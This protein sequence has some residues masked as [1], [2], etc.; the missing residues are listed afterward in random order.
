MVW[1]KAS[2]KYEMDK[3]KKL[4]HNEPTVVAVYRNQLPITTVTNQSKTVPGTR[5]DVS[6]EE[7]RKYTF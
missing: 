1:T 5:R 3:L 2:T 7:F 6:L 4:I